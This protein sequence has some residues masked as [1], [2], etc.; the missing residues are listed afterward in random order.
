MVIAEAAIF[1]SVVP[2]IVTAPLV[3]ITSGVPEIVTEGV[4]VMLTEPATLMVA[5]VTLTLSVILDDWR[6]M[7]RVTAAAAMLTARLPTL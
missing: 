4:P 6:L 1:T 3:I 2:E 7:L 5:L